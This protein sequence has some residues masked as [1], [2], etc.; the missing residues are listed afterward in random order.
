MGETETAYDV[1]AVVELAQRKQ[2]LQ[3]TPVRFPVF[4]QRYEDG[5]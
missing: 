1:V 5:P 4:A 2:K 3:K